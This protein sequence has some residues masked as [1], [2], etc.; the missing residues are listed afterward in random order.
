MVTREPAPDDEEV[1]GKA[2]PLIVEWRELKDTHPNQGRGLD[3]LMDR[4]RLL[5]VELALLEEHGMTLPPEK[6]P[7]WGLGR[8]GQTNWRRTALFDTRVAIRKRKLLR[9]V[10]RVCTLG[11]WWK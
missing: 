7:L 1:F 9:R 10:R 2:W 8:S 6:Q 5:V 3:W 4:E 11:L